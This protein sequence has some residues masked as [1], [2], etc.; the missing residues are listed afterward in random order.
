LYV[1]FFGLRGLEGNPIVQVLKKYPESVIKLLIQGDYDVYS[2]AIEPLHDTKEFNLSEF[3]D[4]LQLVPER[5]W[6][7]TSLEGKY[8]TLPIEDLDAAL[9]VINDFVRLFTIFRA[10]ANILCG[11]DDYFENYVERFWNWQNDLQIQESMATIKFFP[12]EV[13]SAEK[14]IE[15][16]VKRVSVNAYERDP[17]ARQKCIDYYGLD[18]SACGFN[19]CKVFRE[20]GEG[21]IHVHHI[22]PISEIAEEYE[23][24]PVKD[25]RPVCPNCH[26]MIHRRSPPLSIEEIKKLLNTPEN[27]ERAT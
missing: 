11:E 25:L 14:F 20:L 1:T 9:P 15:G 13:D 4:K 26:A 6:H 12:N 27:E 10:A 5:D 24:D 3:I 18:C 8:L 21:F 17:K 22:R 16:S 7:K 19:F 2:E 23:V